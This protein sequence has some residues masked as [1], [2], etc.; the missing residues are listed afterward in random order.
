MYSAVP[1]RR[2]GLPGDQMHKDDALNASQVFQ[3]LLSMELGL[4]RFSS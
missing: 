3:T 1:R 4:G 2:I